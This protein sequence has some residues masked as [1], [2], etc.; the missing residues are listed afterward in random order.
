MAR[1]RATWKKR[2]IQDQGVGKHKIPATPIDQQKI[3]ENTFLGISKSTI[4]DFGGKG[5]DF[6]L[7]G[8]VFFHVLPFRRTASGNYVPLDWKQKIA[9]YAVVSLWIVLTAQKPFAILNML[10]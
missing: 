4:F 2:G 7:K 8:C 10:L 1:G 6:L 3:H 9:H 5:F